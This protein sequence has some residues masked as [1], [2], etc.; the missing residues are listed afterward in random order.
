MTANASFAGHFIGYD[1]LEEWAETTDKARP[2]Y[3]L[4][5]QEPGK[6]DS[7]G[8]RSDDLVIVVAQTVPAEAAT[9]YV[10]LHV[11][12]LEYLNG[13][14]WG[15]GHGERKGRSNQVW[16]LVQAWLSEQGFTVRQ[17]A[18]AHPKDLRLLDGWANF[19]G[20]DQ[21]QERYYRKE[22]QAA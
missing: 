16:E 2:V 12:S 22:A 5:I 7:H 4:P 1:S 14:P 15:D 17:A 18:V 8:I 10:R 11:T 13:S 3:A 21:K 9:H 19:I 20:Y 6:T